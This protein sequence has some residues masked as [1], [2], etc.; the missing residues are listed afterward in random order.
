VNIELK[1]EW[2][3]IDKFKKKGEQDMTLDWLC[4]EPNKA[5]QIMHRRIK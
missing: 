5:K 3:R 1:K 2:Q 4:K